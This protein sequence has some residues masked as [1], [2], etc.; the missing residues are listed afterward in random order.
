[1]RISVVVTGPVAKLNS[2]ANDSTTS[3]ALALSYR[4]PKIDRTSLGKA[5]VKQNSG[6][7]S[8]KLHFP[9]LLNSTASS[10]WRSPRYRRLAWGLYT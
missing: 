9:K 10:S 1:M 5:T 6:K 7:A 4:G 2:M 8:V 3:A